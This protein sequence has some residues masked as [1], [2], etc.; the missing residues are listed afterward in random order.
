MNRFISIFVS[1]LLLGVTGSQV[2]A[3]NGFEME[4][5]VMEASARYVL[6]REYRPEKVCR[7]VA[8]TQPSSSNSHTPEILGA[9]IGGAV[10]KE[11]SDSN[12]AKVAGALLGASIARD[13]EK[14]NQ[15]KNAQ[16]V[17]TQV[18]CET[19]QREVEV[20][21]IDGYDVSYKF[22]GVVFKGSVDERPGDTLRIWVST[23]PLN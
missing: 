4:V 22:N 21:K 19:I 12:T 20:R 6:V 10:G 23:T 8:V 5:P 9:L 16:T 17:G 13:I 18:V 1:G 11:V 15:R 7:E 14:Q 3:A 2:M